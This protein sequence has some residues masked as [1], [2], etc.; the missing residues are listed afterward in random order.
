VAN[1]LWVEEIKREGHYEKYKSEVEEIL[2]AEEA[3]MRLAISLQELMDQI[4]KQQAT[5]KT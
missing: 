1:R 5:K 2:R 4:Q 3:E